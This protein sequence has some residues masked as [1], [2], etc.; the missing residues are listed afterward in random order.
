MAAVNVRQARQLLGLPPSYSA[1]DVEAA[2]RAR[3]RFAH[4]DTGGSTETFQALTESRR[5]LLRSPAPRNVV[6]A[7]DSRLSRRLLHRLR[8]R[9]TKRRVI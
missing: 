7:H 1:A 3:V 2:Y 5:V 4:P 8:H 6:I 9:R